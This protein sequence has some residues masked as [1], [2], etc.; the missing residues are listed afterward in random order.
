MAA[1]FLHLYME[2]FIKPILGYDPSWKYFNEGKVFGHI[3]GYYGC[4]EAQG[5]GTLHCH[6]LV[7]LQGL[8]DPQEIKDWALKEGNEPFQF[9]PA[10]EILLLYGN[11]YAC[12]VSNLSD[13]ST[14]DVL[15]EKDFEWL[16]QECQSHSHT[17]SCYK[18]CKSSVNK[19]CRYN[20]KENVYIPQTTIDMTTSEMSYK[21][22][23]GMI[24]N[25]NPTIL[26]ALCCNVD[27][28][29]IGSGPVC[30]SDFV[31]YN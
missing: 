25:Y 15:R 1:E 10:P 27:I 14:T 3:K 30:E 8:L 21:V 18:C 31:L 9:D 28:K 12:A 5:R 4:I 20:L 16:V 29:F 2:N 26:K 24:N 22:S 7:W 23:N 13:I 17:A 11:Q 6:M 19:E